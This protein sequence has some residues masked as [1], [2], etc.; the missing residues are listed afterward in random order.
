MF[1]YVNYDKKPL[2]IKPE[3]PFKFDVKPFPIKPTIKIPELKYY[4]S[5]TKPEKIISDVKVPILELSNQNQFKFNISNVQNPFEYMGIKSYKPS[6][7][8]NETYY[9]YNLGNKSEFDIIASRWQTEEGT[10]NNLDDLIR[11]FDGE[12]SLDD[13]R[14]QNEEEETEYN[15]G[16]R[17]ILDKIKN[18]KPDEKLEEPIEIPNKKEFK[19]KM[20]KSTQIKIQPA[21]EESKNSLNDII[22][23]IESDDEKQNEPEKIEYK[24]VDI[25]NEIEDIQKL[26][27]EEQEKKRR[28]FYI[29][30]DEENKMNNNI[31]DKYNI[32]LNKLN[33]S[34][35]RN[36]KTEDK[37]LF[38][39][40]KTFNDSLPSDT[41][42]F[43]GNTQLK[44][45]V[46]NTLTQKMETLQSRINKVESTKKNLK[47][48][49]KDEIRYAPKTKATVTKLS[50]IDEPETQKETIK[51]TSSIK[52]KPK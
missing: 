16:L 5:S 42:Q 15:K 20:R 6:S 37:K 51:T 27:K 30:L 46:L 11:N 36:L 10:A 38:K 7:Y 8:K 34:T 18:K 2:Y 49:K 50:N 33:T 40:I 32:I 12:G 29:K 13:I 19:M 35:A 28:E 25:E 39:E 48:D 44:E 14:K 26:T 52:T 41:K 45:T 17:E 22:T 47:E 9:K 43:L 21:F 31:Y 1:N 4:D 23:K 24:E 3:N